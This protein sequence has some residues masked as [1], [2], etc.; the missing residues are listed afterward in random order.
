M[1]A[2]GWEQLFSDDQYPYTFSSYDSNDFFSDWH[3]SVGKG[4]YY[5]Y[6]SLFSDIT[7][8]LRWE[9]A[10]GSV[11]VRAWGWEHFFLRIFFQKTFSSYI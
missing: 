11:G 4:N 2:S 3:G 5:F 9:C 1:G 8:F 6:Y 10:D 7:L